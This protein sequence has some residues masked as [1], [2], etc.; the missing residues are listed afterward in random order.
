MRALGCIQPQGPKN[1]RSTGS[2]PSRTACRGQH[3]GPGL[4][5]I[6]RTRT[7]SPSWKAAADRPPAVQWRRAVH[8]RAS[9][10]RS[11]L[12]VVQ[13]SRRRRVGDQGP[14]ASRRP[15]ARPGDARPEDED[16]GIDPLQGCATSWMATARH[17]CCRGTHRGLSLAPTLTTDD[18]V[19]YVVPAHIT[20]CPGPPANSPERPCCW[21]CSSWA[22]RTEGLVPWCWTSVCTPSLD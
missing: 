8:V 6:R 20:T 22:N 21:S 12:T 4:Q 3:G 14:G 15:G 16:D 7:R 11:L 2:A 18:G 9:T 1:S 10:R 5:R 17:R 19:W 13:R